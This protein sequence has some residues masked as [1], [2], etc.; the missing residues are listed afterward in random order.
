MVLELL[1]NPP[2]EAEMG[3]ADSS[4]EEL[5]ARSRMMVAQ[6]QQQVAMFSDQ[7]YLTREGGLLKTNAVFKEGQLL[8]NGKPFPPRLD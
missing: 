8:V 7:G 5:E 6:F 2:G 4:A 3:S 1:R